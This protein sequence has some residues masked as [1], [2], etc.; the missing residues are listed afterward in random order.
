M[1]IFSEKR[2]LVGIIIVLVIVNL[3]ALIV[4][5]IGR[6]QNGPPPKGPA[7]EQ[8][9]LQRLMHDE[10]GFDAAQIDTYLQ[11]R[12]AHREQA[13]QME[14]EIRQLKK[15]MFDEVLQETPEPALSD[16]LLRLTQEKQAQLEQLTYQHLLDLK[17]LCT[18]EQQKEL[19]LLISEV[20]QRGAKGGPPPQSL[21]PDERPP[22]MSERGKPGNRPE[23][24]RRPK[25]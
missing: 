23:H 7:T 22:H 11:L 8:K 21:P 12:Q 4:L 2:T 9:H 17:K 6:P 3:G 1:D 14:M 24:P 25:H 18:P 15:Q 16:S 5:W 19:R 13:Q 10:L 20:F